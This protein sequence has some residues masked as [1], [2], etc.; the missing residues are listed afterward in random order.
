MDFVPVEV[1]VLSTD[2]M[3]FDTR[4]WPIK[5]KLS[6]ETELFDNEIMMIVGVK[7]CQP[8]T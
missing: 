5:I 7:R 3:H 1:A 2:M 6:Y 4:A 8:E